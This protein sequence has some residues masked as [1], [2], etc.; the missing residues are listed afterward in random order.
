MDMSELQQLL[1]EEDW[2]RMR[3]WVAKTLIA[4]AEVTL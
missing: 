2:T 1:P 4:P 3:Q